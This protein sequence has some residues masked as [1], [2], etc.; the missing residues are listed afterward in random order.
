MSCPE[1]LE[2]FL[3]R[4]GGS[5]DDE[6]LTPERE[7]EV[8]DHVA[9]CPDCQATLAELEALGRALGEPERLPE[10]RKAAFVADVV[11]K[12]EAKEPAARA[13]RPQRFWSMS[14]AIPVVAAACCALLALIIVPATL[15]LSAGDEAPLSATLMSESESAAEPT[16][17]AQAQADEEATGRYQS[18]AGRDAGALRGMGSA[19]TPGAPPPPPSLAAAPAEM[20]AQ[21]EAE[22]RGP[23]EATAR[24]RPSSP[25]RSGNRYGIKGPPRGS[26]D[27]DRLLNDAIGGGGGTARRP[28]AN[29]A[30]APQA[31]RPPGRSEKVLGASGGARGRGGPRG[32]SAPAD[33]ALGSMQPQRPTAIDPNGRFATTYRP[34]RGRLAQF[35]TALFRGQVPEPALALV[36][37]TGR[38]SGPEIAAPEERALAL[39]LRAGMDRVPADGGPVHLAL[40]LRSTAREPANRPDVAVHLVMDTSGSMLGDAIEHARQA[41]RQLVELLQPGDR[42]SLVS[43][44]TDAQIVVEEGTVGPRRTSILGQINGLQARGGTN[45]EA[46]LRL[47]YAQAESSRDDAVQLVIVLSDGQPNQGITN[48]WILSEMSAAAFQSGVETTTIGVGD[49]YEPL[50][51]STLAEYGAGGYYY[52]PDA[53]AI[54]GVLRAELDVRTHPVARG[55]E[56]RVRLGDGVEL[57]EAYGSRRLNEM[58]AQRV[59][60]TEV[61]IDQQEAQRSGIRQDRQEDRDEGMRFF[62]PGFAR[63]DQHTILLRLRVPEG[64]A[65]STLAL[66]EVELRY[67]DRILLSNQGDERTVTVSYAGDP[68]A[69]LATLDRDVR[70][71][72]YSFRTGQALQDVAA[73]LSRG[74]RPRALAIL[75]ERSELLGRAAEELNDPSLRAEAERL[76]SF[77]TALAGGG[78]T[79]QLMMGAILQR[80]GSGLMR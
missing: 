71:A 28:A 12:I 61:A 11:K 25:S 66:A 60:R 49:R 67:K 68:E 73:R 24:H 16:S 8:A 3:L 77:R 75:Y 5:G 42:F 45:L 6:G 13:Q 48:P 63:D 26:R 54:E 43:Y 51:M 74:D 29:P 14:V 1:E 21:A 20:P 41:A 78:V 30:P 46:G 23:R 17:A 36:A 4:E 47:G 22:G 52:L 38:G 62:I 56:L 18:S 15:M 39:D 33:Q 79:N 64:S 40:T 80:A 34:G 50:V 2:L 44:S 76:D 57:L 9:S 10:G 69:A 35:E 19:G 70:R 37:D 55:V 59:R 27:V 32:G 53:S 31:A 58:E 65:G 72:V 7:K